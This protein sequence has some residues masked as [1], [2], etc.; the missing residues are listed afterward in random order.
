VLR[1]PMVVV[2]QPLDRAQESTSPSDEVT[3]D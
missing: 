3:E 1:A 2:A